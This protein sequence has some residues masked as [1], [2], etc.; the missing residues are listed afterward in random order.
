MQRSIDFIKAFGKY[1]TCADYATTS[2][3]CDVFLFEFRSLYRVHVMTINGKNR[4]KIEIS[5]SNRDTEKVP[6]YEVIQTIDNATEQELCNVLANVKSTSKNQ[7]T[8][9]YDFR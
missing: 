5:I 6:V 7:Q 2:G 3:N 8:F 1:L 9:R 4:F